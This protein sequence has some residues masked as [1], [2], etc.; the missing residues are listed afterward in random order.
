MVAAGNPLQINALG[1]LLRPGL[2]F[3]NRQRGAGTRVVLEEM[4]LAR[5]I[6]PHRIEG[7]EHVE[8]VAELCRARICIAKPC[9]YKSVQFN[10]YDTAIMVYKYYK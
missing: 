10:N 6:D 3:A 2:R 1:D 5:N 9:T 4:L 8:P 7:F